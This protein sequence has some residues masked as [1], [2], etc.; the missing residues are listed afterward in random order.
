M[1]DIPYP[2]NEEDME[3]LEENFTY[4]PPLPAYNQTERYADLRERCRRLAVHL[5]EQCPRSR[6][7]SLAL[8]NLEQVA[9]WANSAIARH[10]RPLSEN[11]PI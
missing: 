9:M 8:T 6:E 11:S 4:H 5:M 2:L 7:L 10:E 3:R 1:A